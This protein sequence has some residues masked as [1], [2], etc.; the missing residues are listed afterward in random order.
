MQDDII[1][2]LTHE[3]KEEVIHN[4]LYKRRL[5]NEQIKYVNE[6]AEIAAQ[7]EEKLYRRFARVYGLLVLP[8][9]INIFVSLTGMQET[10]FETRFQ[11]DPHFR[12]GLRLIKVYSLTLR[13]KSR[14]LLIES[15]CRLYTWSEKYKADYEN[16]AHELQAAN[17]NLKKFEKDHDL[18][19][20]L[21]FLRDMNVE[22][23]E[24]KHF[25]GENF[26][27]EEMASIETSLRLKPVRME[28]FKLIPPQDL[29]LPTSIQKQLG[30]LADNVYSKCS[31]RVQGIIQ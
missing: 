2:A 20:M 10:P 5:I 26:T 1:S 19:I 21:S 28:L 3:V 17:Y 16:L 25:L 30:A 6:L 11:N 22:E 18:L 8:E 15:Y 23:L 14:K 12:K 13:A 31:G 9:F 29:T 4:Y 27:P 24:K 7:L